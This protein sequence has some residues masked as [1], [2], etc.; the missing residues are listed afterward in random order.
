MPVR[1]GRDHHG[2]DVVAVQQLAEIDVRRAIGVAV[3]VVDNLL[4]R[5]PPIRLG[6]GDGDK[7]HVGF[8]QEAAE[9]IGASISQPE[10]ADDDPITGRDG[11]VPPSARAGTN[12]GT[13]HAA[14][15]AVAAAR[16]LRREMV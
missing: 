16:N 6:V 8:G 7:L 9:H 12:V 13:A 3:L 1:A 4:D 10:S 2:V 15:A 5:R 11:S 14:P